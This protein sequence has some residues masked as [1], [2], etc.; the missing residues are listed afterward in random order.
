MSINYLVE[1]NTA[2][3]AFGSPV[4]TAI[5]GVLGQTPGQFAESATADVQ[6]TCPPG[7]KFV[8]ELPS[9][10]KFAM[11]CTACD[12][13]CFRQRAD[14]VVNVLRNVSSRH[15]EAQRLVNAV[16]GQSR[17]DEET[18][19]RNALRTLRRISIRSQV[20]KRQLGERK[21]DVAELPDRPV[22]QQ[23]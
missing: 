5:N 8:V 3:I 14:D 12:A 13:S 9:P 20:R 1:H 17:Y 18:I 23:G 6:D 2:E 4:T 7:C 19:Y 10:Q 15:N 22:D 11:G 21:T 16:K